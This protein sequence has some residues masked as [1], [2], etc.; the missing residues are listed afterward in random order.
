MMPED[1]LI[2]VQLI[3]RLKENDEA[4]LSIIYK[5]YWQPLYI[6]AFNILK[7][8]QVCE[9]IIQELFIKLWN[10]RHEIEITISL[11][12]YLYASIRYGVYRQIRLGAVRTEIY[13]NLLERLHSPAAYGNI[14]YKELIVQVNTVVNKLP[15]KCKE[16]Y[17][18]SREEHLSHKQIAER[19]NI[20]T[21]TVENHLTKAL[22]HLRTSLS[23]TL[24]AEMVWIFLKK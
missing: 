19:L 23:A 12:A 4:A 7:D 2:D 20:S 1:L 15:E 9:D 17:K 10:N 5:K 13:D 6:S 18:L 3:D 21:K 11:K 14:E 8:K 16:V 24:I 22:H